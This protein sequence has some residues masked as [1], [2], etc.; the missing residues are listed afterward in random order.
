M[1]HYY[2][3]AVVAISLLYVGCDTI[4]DSP[5]PVAISSFAVTANPFMVTAAIVT[6]N[7]ANTD[8]V[9][10][11]Y[12]RIGEEW[13]RTPNFPTTNK[14]YPVIGLYP[15]SHYTFR[16]VA[17]NV[18]SDTVVLIT[19][20]LPILPTI[21]VTHPTPG[22]TPGYY[23]VGY[24]GANSNGN[25]GGV[26]YDETG[27][28][29]WYR[30][31]PER[32]A[33]FQKQENGNFSIALTSS[34]T[35]T[36]TWFNELNLFGE[37]ITRYESEKTPN[38]GPHELHLLANGGRLLYGVENPRID[39]SEYGGADDVEIKQC[40]VEYRHNNGLFTWST[41]N[42]MLP[43]D[44]IDSL[45][46]LS[47]NPYHV[48]AIDIDNDGNLLI[49]MRNSSQI[50]KVDIKTGQVLWRLGGKRNQ[51]TWI[52][53]PHQ[54]PSRQHGIRRLP[55]GNILLF[56]NGNEHTPQVSR[57]VEYALD[58]DLKS[59]RLVW[60]YSDP[61][62]YGFAL[63]FAHRIA[64][65]NTVICFGMAQII[66][67]VSPTGR[68]LFQLTVSGNERPYRAFKIASVY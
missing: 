16:L 62:V 51:F 48:N 53:D 1:K 66:R 60:E 45:T 37:I 63:G 5:E 38:T 14:R 7:V 31:F 56:D 24:T 41:A 68:V 57:A 22:V 54:G 4:S 25:Y 40:V 9:A 18:T 15:E 11:E 17:A 12:R 27:R 50:V 10:I 32:V 19:G 30:L 64:N 46:G 67:E 6:A 43:S 47:V 21:A 8:S 52:D 29:L 3:V 36:I 34:S 44:G 39:L 2:L 42:H 35:P 28:V 59:A 26:I 49:S 58:E 55:N 65:G 13:K 33:D 61:T 23:L 20:E